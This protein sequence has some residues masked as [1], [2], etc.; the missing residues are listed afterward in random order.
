MNYFFS[1]FQRFADFKGRSRRL[2]FGLFF[3]IHNMLMFS[4]YAAWSSAM[5]TVVGEL[6]ALVMIVYFLISLVPWLA[7]GVRRLHDT[8][9]SGWWMLAF[10]VPLASFVLLVALL[11]VGGTKGPN[12]YG[13]PVK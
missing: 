11:F 9:T 7:L 3:L 4:L 6:V 1:S 5:Q 2:E 8:N 12:R 13:E 10:L